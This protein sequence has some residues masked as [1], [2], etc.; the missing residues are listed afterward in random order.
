MVIRNILA[1]AALLCAAASPAFAGPDV[2][3][4]ATYDPVFGA[5]DFSIANYSDSGL[6]NVTLS[7][8]DT[9]DSPSTE[10]LSDLAALTG[11]EDYVFAENQG[12]FIAN[13]AAAL[14]SDST[15]YSLSFTY[16][17]VTYTSAVF[18]PSTNFSGGYVDFLGNCYAGNV[19]CA[20]D[21]FS[22]VVATVPE[23]ASL[24]LLAAGLPLI[25]FGLRRRAA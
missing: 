15:G 11:T 25:A 10:T 13:P 22:A 1:G 14:L 24:A 3:L 8:T 7:T 20:V 2:T 4:T 18:T 12:G 6:T 9:T 17:G 23:P 19:A 5:V 16:Q 21:R